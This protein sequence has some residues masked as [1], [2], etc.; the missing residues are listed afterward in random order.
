MIFRD[1][2]CDV[3]WRLSPLD[4]LDYAFVKQQQESCVDEYVMYIAYSESKLF[5]AV[6]L[7][8]RPVLL[9]FTL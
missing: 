4:G 3:F 1:F 2:M 5:K 7:F 9:E 8:L 6:D